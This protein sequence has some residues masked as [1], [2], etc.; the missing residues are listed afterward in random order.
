MGNGRYN[1]IQLKQVI[2]RNFSLYKKDGQIYEIDEPVNDGVFCLAGANGLGKTTFLNAINYGLTG[3]VLAPGKEVYT[4]DSI[5][6][7][8]KDYTK[9]YFDGRIKAKEKAE[10]E[11]LLTVNGRF[12]RIIRSFENREDLRLFEFYE[13]KN[14]KKYA[15]L[16]TTDLSPIE[17]L[18]EYEKTIVKEMDI[19][20][21]SY[22]IFF[23]LYVLTFDENRRMLFWDDRASTS[24]L[25]I[26]FNEDLGDTERVLEMK[27]RMEEYESYGRNAR[28][29]ATQIKN[30]W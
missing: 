10:I 16:E 8:N 20:K 29:Q 5:V 14:G 12:I 15:L 19:G 6:S 18:R 23:Q 21:F 30:G 4:P 9:R 28:W 17:F 24:A 22:F 13:E 26:A 11:L 3:I 25:S 2:I 7:S 27:K 1:F